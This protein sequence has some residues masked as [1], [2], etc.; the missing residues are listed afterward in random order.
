MVRDYYEH[1]RAATKRIAERFLKDDG[2]ATIRHALKL[3]SPVQQELDRIHSASRLALETRAAS[4][5]LAERPLASQ[6]KGL[7]SSEFFVQQKRIA[8]QIAAITA[9]MQKLMPSLALA[10][11]FKPMLS[12]A[13]RDAILG[14]QLA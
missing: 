3:T 1:H 8:D 13:L 7:A 4:G 2:L 6:L 11:R 5:F 14:N 9:P 12:P 10:E